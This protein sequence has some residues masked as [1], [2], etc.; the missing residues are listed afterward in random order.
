[1]L[2]VFEALSLPSGAT[3]G[4]VCPLAPD[5]KA[6]MVPGEP[7]RPGE[8][9]AGRVVEAYHHPFATATARGR[10]ML[11]QLC[12]CS[13]AL[14]WLCGT[15]AQFNGEDGTQ[16]PCAQFQCRL[17]RTE[18]AESQLLCVNFSST[19]MLLSKTA[20]Y[21]HI[22]RWVCSDR[23]KAARTVLLHT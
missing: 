20:C 16:K 2:R 4:N 22:W 15:T 6:W 19:H 7:G 13:P 10:C 11:M 8:S 23:P 1:M 5:Q 9:A 14:S 18:F 12:W 21:C 3:R 17:G